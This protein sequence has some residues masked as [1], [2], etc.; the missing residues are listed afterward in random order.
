MVLR[1]SIVTATLITLAGCTSTRDKEKSESQDQPT[2]VKDA[3]AEAVKEVSA[4]GQ[5]MTAH[6]DAESDKLRFEVKAESKESLPSGDAGIIVDN[7]KLEAKQDIVNC[8]KGV[9]YVLEK[10]IDADEFKQQHT[11]VRTINGREVR[12][13]FEIPPPVEIR[14]SMSTWITS[15][16]EPI[17]LTWK[18]FTPENGEQ[19]RLVLVTRDTTKSLPVGGEA[20]QR[21]TFVIPA[22]EL[23]SLKPGFLTVQFERSVQEANVAG[24][25]LKIVSSSETKQI[26]LK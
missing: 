18:P 24:S 22:S 19:L 20:A 11:I 14:T 9:C 1:V 8:P 7:D 6:Y 5:T 15:R 16:P 12:E 21:G 2:A 26:Y 4:P 3:A 17:K 10:K 25:P 13:Q 23:K